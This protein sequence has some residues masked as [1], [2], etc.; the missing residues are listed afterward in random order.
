M[1]S[2][3]GYGSAHAPDSNSVQWRF[4]LAFQIV[5]SL[6][7]LVGMLWLPETPRY[8]VETDRDEEAKRILHKLHY[9]GTNE[10]WI[11]SE[12]T[13]IKATI[14]AEKAITA[15]GWLVMFKVPQWRTR[16]IQATLVQTFTQLTGNSN[17]YQ[18]VIF[19]NKNN[20]QYQIN[21]QQ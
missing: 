21:L 18:Y 1:I 12:F 17:L 8:L 15:P 11:R 13:E 19:N 10:D 4:P 14:Q 5:P 16:L 3:I 2:W 20:Y 9:D 7:L 6:L